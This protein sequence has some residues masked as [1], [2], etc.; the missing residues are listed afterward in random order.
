MNYFAACIFASGL[1]IAALESA[2]AQSPGGTGNWTVDS[3]ESQLGFSGMQTG[4]KFSG[5]FKRFDATIQFDPTHPQS[6]YAKVTI[7]ISSAATGDTQRDEAMPG[8]DWLD[9]KD[10]PKAVFEA[11]T[12]LS[13]GGSDYL[14]IGTLTIR[15]I[16]RRETLPFT[17][18]IDGDTAHANGRLE[19][20]RTEFG[21]GQGAWSSGQWVALEVGVDVD[22]VA[23]RAKTQS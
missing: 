11:K 19:L 2:A 15:G 17:L 4:A 20:I 23:H 1:C 16:V 6:G 8:A 7:D 5:R 21:V 13:K 14:A 18:T 22:L 12:F 3:S 9:A 10:F